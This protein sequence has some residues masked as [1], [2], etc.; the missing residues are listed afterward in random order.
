[1]ME[2]SVR[3][4]T[5]SL[6][7]GW[8]LFLL[9]R[10]RRVDQVAAQAEADL[11]TRRDVYGWDLLAWAR[12][13]QGRDAEARA[14]M[15]QALRMGTRDAMLL[16]HAGMIAHALH[17]DAAAARD[18]SAALEI[19]PRFHPLQARRARAVLDSIRG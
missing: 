11:R 13:R 2:V 7:R 6:H 8:G 14:A 5:G 19:D 4:Q 17:D 16:Y 3:R 18:L 12:H 9:D 15:A 1:V 10:G